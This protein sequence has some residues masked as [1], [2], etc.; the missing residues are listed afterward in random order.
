MKV[1]VFGTKKLDFLS[2]DG[3]QVKGLQVYVGFESNG[4][5]G[6]QTDKIFLSETRFGDVEI[7]VGA[8][9]NISYNRYGKV[10]YI[11]KA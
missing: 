8:D 4:V 1:V 2:N 11:A 7:V 6:M 3:N 10:D 9:Y 5:N